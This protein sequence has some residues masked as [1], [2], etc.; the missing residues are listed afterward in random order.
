MSPVVGGGSSL[1][2]KFCTQLPA[3]LLPAAP[4]LAL[5][6][7]PADAP[8]L[9]LPPAPTW[10]PPIPAAPALANAPAAAPAP[11]KL[12]ALLMLPP[13]PAAVPLVPP[14]SEPEPELPPALVEG[15]LAE[16]EQPNARAT[17]QKLAMRIFSFYGRS[18]ARATS[19]KS[20]EAER[21]F[22]HLACVRSRSLLALPDESNTTVALAGACLRRCVLHWRRR[23]APLA[24]K[25]G[26]NGA[27]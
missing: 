21:N 27:N 24:T 17:R 9:A 8:P 10:F 2:A 14:R 18:A 12:P 1:Q 16:L 6:P 7:A 15:S 11:A 4:P 13:E 20:V 5:P 22:I 26:L 25:I 23:Q 3:P 19:R